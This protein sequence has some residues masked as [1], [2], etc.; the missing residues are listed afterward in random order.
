M[1]HIYVSIY[2]RAFLFAK[3]YVLEDFFSCLFFFLVTPR[4]MGVWSSWAR[5]QIRDSV[6]TYA[7]AAAT[8]DPLTHCAKPGIELASWQCRDS[9]DPVAPWQELQEDFSNGKIVSTV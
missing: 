5:D 6:V 8:Q 7:A 3:S 4:H 1:A 2:R 9:T